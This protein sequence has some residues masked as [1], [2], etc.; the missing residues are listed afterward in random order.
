M[1]PSALAD[2]APARPL[3]MAPPQGSALP[4]GTPLMRTRIAPLFLAQLHA[5]MGSLASVAAEFSLP[6][7]AHQLEELSLPLRRFREFASR[8]AG[9][10]GDPLLGLHT[11]MSLRPGTYGIIEFLLRSAATPR[12]SLRQLLRFVPLFNNVL[13]LSFIED[14]DTAI[15]EA[16]IPGEPLCLGREGNEFALAMFVGIGRQLAGEAWAPEHVSFA[17]PATSGVEELS[18]FFR[19]GSVS[20]GAGYL[21][22][23]FKAADLAKPVRTGD[24]ALHE[25]LE[26]EASALTSMAT[27]DDLEL[28][29]EAIRA[30]L[31]AGEPSLGE[32]AR[33]LGMS[34][35]TFQRRLGD[36]DTSF[37]AVVD[38]VR[39]SLAREY[40]DHRGRPLKEV[41]T[42]L[43]YADVRA[44][45]RAYKRWTGRTPGR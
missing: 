16:E 22:L 6:D 43:G 30:A 13:R 1:R 41:A 18:Q 5:R 9:L 14:G 44:F 42:V 12:D 28:A 36:R 37:R 23:R 20:F 4:L 38:Q 45:G 10:T 29:R 33:A 40:L 11:A 26:R 34:S 39:E 8:I 2:L 21:G 15:V 24:D 35:R 17:H 7:D 27:T 3:A 19:S 32:V 25:F 31:R